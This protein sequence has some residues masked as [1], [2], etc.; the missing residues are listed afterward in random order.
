MKGRTKRKDQKKG[1]KKDSSQRQTPY[2]AI[3]D[4]RDGKGRFDLLPPLALRQLA[5]Q[6]EIGAKKYGERNWEKGMPLSWFIDSGL[7]H[8]FQFLSGEEDEDHL[9]AAAWNIMVALETRE[10]VKLGQLPEELID[11]TRKKQKNMQGTS[12]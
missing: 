2:G 10:R 5:L 3:R 9:R 4:S 12:G 8:L 1:P 6:F 7:R 11:L